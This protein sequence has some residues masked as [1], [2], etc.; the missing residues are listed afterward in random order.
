MWHILR[1]RVGCIS[2][3]LYALGFFVYGYPSAEIDLDGNGPRCKARSNTKFYIEWTEI[4][5]HHSRLPLLLVSTTPRLLVRRSGSLGPERY[6][7]AYVVPIPGDKVNHTL[8]KAYRSRSDA[9]AMEASEFFMTIVSDKLAPKWK[10]P[11][12]ENVIKQVVHWII[13]LL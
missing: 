1:G 2:G 3:T 9:I 4:P 7:S 12:L 6:A 13:R 11:Y 8:N 5:Y 10:S